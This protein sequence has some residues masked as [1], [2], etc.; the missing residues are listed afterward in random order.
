MSSW[1]EPSPNTSHII[2]II[3]VLDASGCHFSI[4]ATRWSVCELFEWEEMSNIPNLDHPWISW[5]ANFDL[6]TCISGPGETIG[7]FLR[8]ALYRPSPAAA[9]M[10]AWV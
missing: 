3:Y 2:L 9:I 4:L 6:S 8:T 5:A 1:S 7:V 10:P